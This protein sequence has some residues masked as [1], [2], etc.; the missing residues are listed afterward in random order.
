FLTGIDRRSRQRVA[1]LRLNV[2]DAEFFN[3]LITA[4]S[5][6][7]L[8]A[9]T[10]SSHH[11]MLSAYEE[12]Q[13]QVLRIVSPLAESAHGDL[14]NTWGTFLEQRA[15]VVLLRVPDDA[16]A[17]RMFETLNDRG[18]RTSQADLIKNYLFGRAGE[19]IEEVQSRWSYMRGALE[20]S[21]EDDIT[22]NFLRHAL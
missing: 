2:D 12:A 17:Y 10:R 21:D 20:A 5:Q 11:L 16:D 18:L 1:K 6:G 19:R 9:P 13:K 22:I 8:P 3:G 15:L 7:P 14:L 4:T